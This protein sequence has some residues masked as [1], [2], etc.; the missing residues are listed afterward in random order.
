MKLMLGPGDWP[1]DEKTGAWMDAAY[2]I[3]EESIGK[4]GEHG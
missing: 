2:L 1:K 3:L 4:D